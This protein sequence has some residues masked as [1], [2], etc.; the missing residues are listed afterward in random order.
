MSKFV[1]RSMSTTD[2]V[3]G[4]PGYPAQQPV[5]YHIYLKR[6]ELRSGAYWTTFMPDVATFDSIEDAIAHG[7][8]SLR[9]ERF[10]VVPF[11]PNDSVRVPTYWDARKGN[12]KNRVIG[13]TIVSH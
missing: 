2:Y 12:Y 10:D 6:R 8:A 4:R 11:A 9:D 7:K 1:I 13:E 3:I 5:P